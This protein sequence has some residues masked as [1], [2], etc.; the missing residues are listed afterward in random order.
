MPEQRA[1][2]S[3]T[4]ILAA[5]EG[6]AEPEMLPEADDE[7]EAPTPEPVSA[8]AL[9]ARHQEMTRGFLVLP[10]EEAYDVLALWSLYT[11]VWPR[12]RFTPYLRV[13]SSEM[14]CG[15]TRVLEVAIE[16]WAKR[17]VV[18]VGGSSSAFIRRAVDRWKPVLLIDESDGW[19]ADPEKS[20]AIRGILNSGFARGKPYG[21]II[22]N[23]PVLLDVFCPKVIAGIGQVSET[24]EDRSI[25][26]P[27]RKK[28]RDETVWAFDGGRAHM[29]EDVAR[30][31]RA[32]AER[33]AADVDTRNIRPSYPRCV[34]DR[35]RDVWYPL[36][37]VAT[38]AGG[39]WPERVSRAAEVLERPRVET[40]RENVGNLILRDMRALWEANGEPEF[41]PTTDVLA[42]LREQE[43]RPWTDW[44]KGM[45]GHRLASNLKPYG[46]SPKARWV[47]GNTTVRGYAVEEL[48]DAWA[49]Y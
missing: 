36:F 29:L 17:P 46:I 23:D 41:L 44:L 24:V 32:Q 39:D 38:I 40:E 37:V 4:E 20:E 1:S 45:T 3:Y 9:L 22:G 42:H 47:A 34:V 35:V 10:D 5:G 21:L 15:K 19:M 7:P 26:I 27:M 8:A 48:R 14:R 33:W 11:Y 18:P 12:F 13:F 16:P 28:R 25:K 43:E 30:G 49:R 2:F 6:P 31:W